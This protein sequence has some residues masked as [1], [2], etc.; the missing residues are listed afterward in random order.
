[1]KVVPFCSVLHF[2]GAARVMKV[3]PFCSVLCFDGAA[4][5]RMVVLHFVLYYTLMEMPEK[6]G[7]PPFCSVCFDAATWGRRLR[8]TKDTAHN[9]TSATSPTKTCRRKTWR[10]FTTV[11]TSISLLSVFL[12]HMQSTV[13]YIQSVCGYSF[14]TQC[15]GISHT[16][17][18]LQL[19]QQCNVQGY[20][21]D[22]SQ[23]LAW[24]YF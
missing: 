23:K 3:V 17:L 7:S 21:R 1:M 12:L 5:G 4:W 10:N 16:L 19:S 14:T 2:D 15:R 11:M 13:H 8:A 20:T 24:C 9:T 22:P 6:D 18:M